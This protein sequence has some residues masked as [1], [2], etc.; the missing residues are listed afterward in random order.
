[1]KTKTKLKLIITIAGL[2]IS[3]EII[4]KKSRSPQT[5]TSSD[6][7]ITIHNRTQNSN[8]SQQLR[9]SKKNVKPIAP[10]TRLLVNPNKKVSY[11]SMQKAIQNLPKKLAPADVVALRDLLNQPTEAFPKRLRPIE[12]N[13]IKNDILDKLLRQKTLPSGIGQQLADMS[14]NR[15]NDPVWRDYSIQY[16]PQYYERA[17]QDPSIREE[18]RT[19]IREALIAALDER[20]GTLAGTALIALELLSKKD[21]TFNRKT[22]L[23]TGVDI[24]TDETASTSSRL[25]ALRVTAKEG[26]PNAIIDTAR[27]LAQTGE[28]VLLRSAALVTL[29]E[30]GNSNDQELIESYLQSDNKQIAAAAKIALTKLK[31]R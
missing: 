10:V 19:Q 13:S 18:E 20:D 1:M 26:D 9:K 14:K 29:G 11:S 22:I 3:V 15:K 30:I 2:L 23:E 17:T 5:P 16:M 24:A 21:Q 12:V 31:K 28:T 6:S 27:T 8:T 7:V 25:T 4:V